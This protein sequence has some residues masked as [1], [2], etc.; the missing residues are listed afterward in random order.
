MLMQNGG[1]SQMDLFDP[2]PELTKHDGQVHDERSRRS[3][4]AASRTSCWPRRSR[5]TAAASA[6]WSCPRCCRTSGRVADD[7]CL[8]RSMYSEHNNHTEG[9]VLLNT[10]KIFPGRPALGSWVSYALGTR[11]PEPARLHRA[12]RPGGLQHQRHAAVAERLAAGPVPRHRVQHAGHARPQPAAGRRPCRR[13]CGA[14]TS[15]SWPSSTRSTAGSYPHESELEARI[16][17]YELA[18]RMQLAA[19]ELLDLSQRVGGD[20]QALRPG[21][22]GDRRLRPALPDGPAA[23]RGGRAL[24]AGLPARQAAV[25]AVGRAH[26]TSR[27]RTRRS[28]R[29]SDQPSAALIN[30]LKSARPAGRARSCSGRASSAG[31]RSRRTAAAATTTATPSACSWPAAASRRGHVH[32]ATD[33]VGYRAA[34]DRVSVPDLHATILH[35][36][37]LDHDR[38]TYRHHGRDETLTDAR[39]TKARVVRELIRA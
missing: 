11:E 29:Q 1:P 30:D 21:Q 2:K 34:E 37:G 9:L 28:A 4:R 12:A 8:V 32:G 7:L 33:D 5:S 15:T 20:A 36:L 6:A 16:R 26:R 23:G 13:T 35:Q 18:A 31:C 19:G 27:P 39:V 3:R 22:P 17:N 38:L 24:R 25:P 10:G 14:T